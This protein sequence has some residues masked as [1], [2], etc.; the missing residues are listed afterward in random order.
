MSSTTTYPI[1][2]ES[3]LD[4]ALESY[5]KQTG[6]DLTKH[7]SADQLQNCHS[8]EDI[9]QLLFEREAEFK[10]Y[11]DDYRKVINCLRPVVQ[12]IHA[13]SGTLSEAHDLVS[14]SQC[15]LL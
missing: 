10:D 5:A 6:V 7:P 14:S 15:V 8:S 13:F 12:V 3:I 1:G 9:T 4:A 2:F 11:R